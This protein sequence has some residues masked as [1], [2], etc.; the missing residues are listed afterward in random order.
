V[1]E[2]LSSAFNEYLSTQGTVLQDI[3]DYTPELTGVAE[4]NILILMNMMRSML[5]VAGM[6]KNLWAEAITA[7][8]YIKNRFTSATKADF[9]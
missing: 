9:T 2:F 1:K 5:K 8:C 7:A 6:P 4:R 3:L